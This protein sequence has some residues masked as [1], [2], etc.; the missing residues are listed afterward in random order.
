[1]SRTTPL[2]PLA[3]RRALRQ[4]GL[5]LQR[6]RRRRRLTAEMVAQRAQITRPTLRRVERGDA[7][8]AVGTYASVLWVLGLGERIGELAAPETDALGLS[9]ADEQLPQRVSG[10]PRARRSAQDRA[11][12]RKAAVDRLTL[13]TGRK[14]ISPGD[15]RPGSKR[16][17][18]L[19]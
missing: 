3:V 4:L 15:K 17:G 9:L 16:R 18:D 19:P 7:S 10:A 5:D 11:Y 2:A 12:P 1:M 14:K 8:V 13:D 6:A